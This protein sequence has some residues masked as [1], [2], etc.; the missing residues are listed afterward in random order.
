MKTQHDVIFTLVEMTPD[1]YGNGGECLSI[2]YGFAESPFGSIIVAS[3]NKGICYMAFY[4]GMQQ[5]ALRELQKHFPH[6]TYHAL[7]DRI[8]QNAIFYFTQDWNMLGEV[9]LHVKGT[10][11][12][13]K[14]WKALLK[15]PMGEL[16]T[17]VTIANYIHYPKASRAV[18]SAVGDNP[19]AFLIPCHRVVKT[20]GEIGRYH[21]GT[22]RKTDM[23]GWE[24]RQILANSK[25]FH[26]E[27]ISDENHHRTA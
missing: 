10:A 9:K 14:V 5:E 15:I 3:T 25:N 2:N 12:Q 7:L 16:S 24:A 18:G 11:F 8:Q 19:V 21:W 27:I 20:S 13:M 4:D 23:I 22:R 1:E 26:N 6:A 17:Y